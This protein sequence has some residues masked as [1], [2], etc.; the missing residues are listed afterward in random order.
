MPFQCSKIPTIFGPEW[1]SV[2]RVSQ[3]Y[4]TH[5]VRFLQSNLR[6]SPVPPKEFFGEIFTLDKGI[7]IFYKKLNR[8]SQYRF[9]DI[10]KQLIILCQFSQTGYYFLYKSLKLRLNNYFFDIIFF[11]DSS[12]CLKKFRI[13]GPL[14][15]RV[16]KILKINSSF[17]S[18]KIFRKPNW[19]YGRTGKRTKA[20]GAMLF[21][22]FFWFFEI[23][24]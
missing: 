15:Q 13:K 2:G 8:F 20:L 17:G 10:W 1:T 18:L 9:S 4:D 19:F 7:N 11:E 24:N 12:G 23:Y 14:V 6:K 3:F 16:W 21:D 22:Q 5:Q